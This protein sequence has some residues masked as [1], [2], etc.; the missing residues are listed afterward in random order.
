MRN[1]RKLRNGREQ[2]TARRWTLAVVGVALLS[3]MAEAE[4][5]PDAEP[6][7]ESAGPRNRPPPLN[8]PDQSVYLLN[9]LEGRVE[10]ILV[11]LV[12]GE[13]VLEVE[14][15]K[16][17]PRFDVKRFPFSQEGLMEGELVK[18][19][20]AKLEGRLVRDNRG[21]FHFKGYTV[22]EPAPKP[23]IEPSV[24]VPK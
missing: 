23:S 2:M 10:G 21:R 1:Q 6:G 18:L 17:P 14:L 4:T 9:E 13:V 11:A 15:S 8:A 22:V 5:P 20:G 24:G 16:L 7:S 3:P 12:D 19:I